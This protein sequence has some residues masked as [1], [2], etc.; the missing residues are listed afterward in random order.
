MTSNRKISTSTRGGMRELGSPGQ[1]SWELISGMIAREIGP[2]HA[3][4]FA[5][6]VPSADGSRIDWYTDGA[7][8]PRAL[9]E[10]DDERRAKVEA[11][12]AG[13]FDDI[14]L[15][16][17]RLEA[18]G[19]AASVRMAEALRN[20][21]TVPGAESVYVFDAQAD[22][23]PLRPVIVDWATTAEERPEA[24]AQA[25]TGWAPRREASATTE[26]RTSTAA[27]P[28]AETAAEAPAAA[29][30]IVAAR[31]PRP[32]ILAA[33][34]LLLLGLL[35]G[36]IYLLLRSCILPGWGLGTCSTAVPPIAADRAALEHRIAG[37]ERDLSERGAACAPR[38]EFA[39]RLDRE[40]AISGE[41]EI[42]LIWNS[43][44]DLDLHVTCPAG[45]SINF[46]SRESAVCGGRLDVDMNV[47]GRRVPDPVEHVYFEE[48]S[49]GTYDIAVMLYDAADDATHPFQLRV[50]SGDRTEEFAGEVSPAAPIWS[51]THDI[52]P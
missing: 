28:V 41:A 39:E 8:V 19:D 21:T 9:V 1:R 16:A 45:D 43:T 2:R 23:T 36:V 12:L 15:H 14:R 51:I 40:S 18:A 38:D 26:L 7:G 22:D 52:A 48:V 44:A 46:Q 4:L 37:L 32:W 13:M 42:A 5:E 47:G 35:A 25:L 17:D 33:L 29:T 50:T 3:A 24:G 34:A 27:A 6:P 49:P 31:D 30:A 20:A 11:E 10:L